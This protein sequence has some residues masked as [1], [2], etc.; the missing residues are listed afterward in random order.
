[1]PIR[2]RDRRPFVTGMTDTPSRPLRQTKVT[3]PYEQHIRLYAVKMLQGQPISETVTAAL[4]RYF[5][6]NHPE[7]DAL[8]HRH[9]A[10]GLPLG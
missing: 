10:D 4:Q 6:A 3:I 7:L 2:P 9:A 5:E 1:M 8:L